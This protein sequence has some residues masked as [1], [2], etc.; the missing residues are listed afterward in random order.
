MRKRKEVGQ[1]WC[2]FFDFLL[3]TPCVAL[4]FSCSAYIRPSR[5]F[6]WDRAVPGLNEGNIFLALYKFFFSFLS[7]SMKF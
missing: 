2:S 7:T 6:V 4:L 5:P 1:A 3:I